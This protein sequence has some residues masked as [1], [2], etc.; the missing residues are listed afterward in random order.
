MLPRKNFRRDGK[1]EAKKKKKKKKK[2]GDFKATK[3]RRS[4]SKQRLGE[5]CSFGGGIANLTL[6]SKKNLRKSH[7]GEARGR[8]GGGRKS[9]WEGN[10]V[11][12]GAFVKGK[13]KRRKKKDRQKKKTLK[14]T[15]TFR[16]KQQEQLKGQGKAPDGPHLEKTGLRFTKKEETCI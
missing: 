2:K 14:G 10:V 13:Q 6:Y 9:L 15:G 5:T 1:E 11:G 16:K 8:G 12:T 3:R 7:K 4:R